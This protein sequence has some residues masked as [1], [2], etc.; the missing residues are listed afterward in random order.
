MKD[1]EKQKK[2][3]RKKLKEKLE[4]KKERK[5]AKE[6]FLL[7]KALMKQHYQ[8]PYYKKPNLP[9]RNDPCLCGS[10]K[11]FKYCCISQ[12]KPESFV[13]GDAPIEE[14]LEKLKEKLM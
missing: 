4:Q 12:F 13:F 10:G 3:E 1:K 6:E 8:N 5:E 2:F 11:K 9:K 7:R 14:K